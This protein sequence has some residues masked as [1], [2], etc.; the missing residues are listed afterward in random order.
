MAV[1]FNAAFKGLNSKN[2]DGVEFESYVVERKNSS[3][4]NN[5]NHVRKWQAKLYIW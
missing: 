1:W 2:D 4:R 5:V 3:M